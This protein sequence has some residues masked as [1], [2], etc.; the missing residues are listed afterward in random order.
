MIS[1]TGREDC[2]S[3]RIVGKGRLRRKG[4]GAKYPNFVDII[5]EWTLKRA[6]VKKTCSTCIKQDD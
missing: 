2:K 3:W 6:S 4:E 1:A 5:F